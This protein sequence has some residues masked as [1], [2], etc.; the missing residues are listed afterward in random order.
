MKFSGIVRQFNHARLRF[1]LDINPANQW[2]TRSRDIFILCF[3]P[4]F[5]FNLLLVYL[6]T[7]NSLGQVRCPLEFDSRLLELFFDLMVLNIEY[8]AI[9]SLIV[10]FLEVLNQIIMLLQIKVGINSKLR[11][12]S[13][14]Q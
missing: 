2:C 14:F 13:P 8:V 9:A 11:D 10:C 5:N 12:G 3:R 1:V 6:L 7:E 4:Y